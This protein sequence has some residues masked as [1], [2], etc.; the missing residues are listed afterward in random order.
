MHYNMIACTYI[1]H[2]RYDLII[3]L[4]LQ[5]RWIRVAF[6]AGFLAGVSIGFVV[7]I[8]FAF[9]YNLVA[10]DKGSPWT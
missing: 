4:L 6:R 9:L 10:E 2:W 3:L 8:C 5:W 1:L 7:V